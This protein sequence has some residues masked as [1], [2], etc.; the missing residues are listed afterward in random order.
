MLKG[1]GARSEIR[2]IS[3]YT[4]NKVLVHKSAVGGGVGSYRCLSGDALRYRHAE[5]VIRLSTEQATRASV[6]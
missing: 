4:A 5:R 3:A 6:F 1:H 2:R